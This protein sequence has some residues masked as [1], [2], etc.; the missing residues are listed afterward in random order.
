MVT[1]N[2]AAIKDGRPLLP[3]SIGGYTTPLAEKW[4][5]HY[6]FNFCA[7]FMIY[8]AADGRIYVAGQTFAFEPQSS[9]RETL[10]IIIRP[11]SSTMEVFVSAAWGWAIITLVV[12][13]KKLFGRDFFLI[14]FYTYVSYIYIYICVPFL[15]SSSKAAPFSSTYINLFQNPAIIYTAKN[16]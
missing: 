12:T 15:T 11:L 6:L 1:Q 10:Q 4:S 16:F 8:A 3:S 14:W 13:K 5:T 7:F 9:F 2:L